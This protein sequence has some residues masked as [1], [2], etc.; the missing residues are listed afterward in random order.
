VSRGPENQFIASV[1]KYLDPAKVYAMKN[2]NEYNGGIADCWYSGVPHDLWVEWKYIELPKRPDTIISLVSG[3]NPALSPLQQDWLQS[4][5]NEGRNVMVGIGS[6][7]GGVILQGLEWEKPML[8]D[9]F[10]DRMASRKDLA[11]IITRFVQGQA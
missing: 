2:H 1:H 5:Y 10:R 4:R 8:P 6:K 7:D 9:E 11:G 3:K